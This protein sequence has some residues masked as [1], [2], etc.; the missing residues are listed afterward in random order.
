ML[1]ELMKPYLTISEFI[2][3]RFICFTFLVLISPALCLAETAN[4]SRFRGPNGT[5][6]SESKNIPLKFSNT[7]NILWKLPL[8]DVGNSA[9]V[10]W[11]NHLFLHSSLPDGSKRFLQCIDSE[12]GKLLWK[13]S[14]NAGVAKT[15]IKNSLASCTPATDGERVYNIIWDGKNIALYAHDFKGEE[16]WKKDLGAFNSQHGPGHS[17]IVQGNKVIFNN[18]QDGTAQ[19]LAFD[20]K[21][22]KT[23]WDIPRKAFRACYSTPLFNTLENGKLELLVATSAGITSYD[24]DKGLENWNYTWSF[25]KM[26]LRTVA[27]PVVTSGVVVACSGDGAGDRHLIAV[28]LGGTGDVTPTNLLWENRKSFPYVPCMISKQE[29]IFS[30]TDKGMAMCNLAISGKELWSERLDSP[31]TASPLMIDNNIFAIG[32]NGD[33]YI[34]QAEGSFKMISKNSLGEPVF[35]TPAVANDKLYIR[36]KDHLFCIG[37]PVK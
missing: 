33:V 23:L 24:A 27:S 20:S 8:A 4:W 14:F 19:L 11:G 15:H 22:G 6:I 32:E 29:Y 37:K 21:T 34:F 31:V 13:K 30:V 28:K 1:V 2:P 12:S 17:P 3:M 36:G 35:S 7:E 9:P 18:D 26:P 10:I 16:V 5:G 25:S